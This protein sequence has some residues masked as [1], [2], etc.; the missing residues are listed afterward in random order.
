MSGFVDV[1][2]CQSQSYTCMLCGFITGILC[3]L[4]VYILDVGPFLLPK[5]G[6]YISDGNTRCNVLPCEAQV[7]TLD[8]PHA[9]LQRRM[10][11]GLQFSRVACPNI[12]KWW[13]MQSWT[14]NFSHIV[15]LEYT[16]KVYLVKEPAVGTLECLMW[17]LILLKHRVYQ[18]LSSVCQ[19]SCE[20]LNSQASCRAL[21]GVGSFK[22]GKP[23]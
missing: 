7:V 10:A 8:R 21:N 3:L 4:L 12:S 14:S 13:L 17:L 15:P 22:R 11:G 23:P 6:S 16:D 5:L 18:A 2:W 9:W 19:R 20:E 1:V